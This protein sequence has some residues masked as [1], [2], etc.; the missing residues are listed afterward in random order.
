M[1]DVRKHIFIRRSGFL[2]VGLTAFLLLHCSHPSPKQEKNQ[3]EPLPAL[4]AP[5]GSASTQLSESEAAKGS[6]IRDRQK[7]VSGIIVID[8]GHGGQEKGAVG[9]TG[10][11][12][13]DICLAIAKRLEKL[14]NKSGLKAIL[15]RRRDGNISLKE[16]TAIANRYQADL[17]ISIHA[18][19]STRPTTKGIETYFLSLEASDDEARMVAVLENKAFGFEGKAIEELGDLEFIL[20]DM[21]QTEYLE[22]SSQLAELIQV[23]LV[24][25]LNSDDRGVKQAPFYVLMGVAMPA[26]LVEMG[27]ISHPLEGERLSSGYIQDKIARALLKS[28]LK[29]QG[30]LRAKRG[31]GS[32]K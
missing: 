1:P 24:Q 18:N 15:T 22:E 16:R 32:R 5:E 28:I 29:F 4:K 2:L 3:L 9:P 11:M 17:F 26:V 31:A 23:Y 13:K 30:L 7:P 27:F 8:P 6:R 20:W 19:A 10:I 14:V 21:A 25:F 12:E